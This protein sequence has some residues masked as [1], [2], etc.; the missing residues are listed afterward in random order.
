MK[1]EAAPT[2]MK[3]T[4][5]AVNAQ[6]QKTHTESVGAFYGK[7]NPV[8]GSPNPNPTVALKKIDARTFEAQ[9]SRRATNFEC[10]R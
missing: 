5:D 6:G 4:I 1:I 3:T 2:G 9:S 10:R 8:N 7:D